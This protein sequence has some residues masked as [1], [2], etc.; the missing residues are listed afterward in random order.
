MLLKKRLLL[1]LCSTKQ[2]EVGSVAITQTIN[3]ELFLNRFAEAIIN[4][5]KS[6]TARMNNCN[7][8]A[9]Y[10]NSFGMVF[11][12]NFRIIEN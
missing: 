5:A 1:A 11:V 9:R 10:A 7:T 6:Q 8:S 12:H 4:V 3:A 2:T